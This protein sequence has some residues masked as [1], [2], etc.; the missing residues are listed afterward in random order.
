M[1]PFI[2]ILLCSSFA[3]V[4]KAQAPHATAPQPAAAD[5]TLRDICFVDPRTG[6]AVGDCGVILHTCDGGTRWQVIQQPPQRRFHRVVAL[7]DRTAVY[8]A[9]MTIRPFTARTE[10][11][12]LRIDPRMAEIRSIA[13]PLMPGLTGCGFNGRGL[14]LVGYASPAHPAGV[15]FL[16]SGRGRESFSVA[17]VD[18]MEGRGPKKTPDPID[19]P[20][21]ADIAE[22]ISPMPETCRGHWRGGAFVGRSAGVLLSA[23]GQPAVLASTSIVMREAPASESATGRRSPLSCVGVDRRGPIYWAAGDTGTVVQSRDRGLSWQ[24]AILGKAGGAGEMLDPAVLRESDWQAILIRGPH[25]WIA[26]TPGSQMLH[27]ADG[28]Q[29]WRWVET[30]HRPPLTSLYFVDEHHGWACGELGAILHTNDGGSTWRRQR[31]FD[32]ITNLVW[33]D[34]PEEIPWNWVASRALG[35]HE[36]T[37]V[38]CRE[39][40]PRQTAMVASAIGDDAIGAA[41]LAAGASVGKLVPATVRETADPASPWRRLEET[42][43]PV[44]VITR[45]NGEP[46]GR[47]LEVAPGT[48]LPERGVTLGGVAANADRFLHEFLPPTDTQR[49]DGPERVASVSASYGA[50]PPIRRPLPAQASGGGTMTMFRRLMILRRLIQRPASAD[51]PADPLQPEPLAWLPMFGDLI[52]TTPPAQADLIAAEV[53]ESLVRQGDWW[54]AGE[55]ARFVAQRNL[56]SPLVE[57]ALLTGFWRATSEEAG[58]LSDCT[59]ADGWPQRFAAAHRDLL[60][61]SPVLSQEPPVALAQASA[62]RRLGRGAEAESIYRR[63]VA[64]FPKTRFARAATAELWLADPRGQPPAPVTACEAVSPRPHLDGALDD[65]IWR[66]GAVIPLA[67]VTPRT[68]ASSVG[69]AATVL[70]ARDAEYLYVGVRCVKLADCEYPSAAERKRDADLTQSDRVEIL[71]DTDRD[72]VTR[73]RL[74]VDAA[75]RACETATLNP[76]YD[77][78]WFVAS[79]RDERQWTAEAAIPLTALARGDARPGDVWAVNFVRWAGGRVLATATGAASTSPLEFLLMKMAGSAEL[80]DV[81]VRPAAYEA[82]DTQDLERDW[83]EIATT[84][85]PRP[86]KG[87][88]VLPRPAL[89][90]PL[91]AEHRPSVRPDFRPLSPPDQERISNAPPRRE[92]PLPPPRSVPPPRHDTPPAPRRLVPP[93]DIFD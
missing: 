35:E 76:F 22:R 21:A 44:Q 85:I 77:P 49:G 46:R 32:R 2:L 59:S 48:L 23:D 45:T 64:S 93:K 60:K 29:S 28:G 12:L 78:R 9:G 19:S 25:I 66:S 71:I 91:P 61:G 34:T 50:L 79:T 27:S 57:H 36:L 33:A 52:E 70:V 65:A 17:P 16:D 67:P 53:F 38:A 89:P 55:V 80:P 4:A 69:P 15:F 14:T 92:Q 20:T 26:G 51:S 47:A 56:Q 5:A 83:R 31:G 3:T 58:L 42:Y 30:G 41:A 72:Y 63:I 37:V 8:V 54:A 6:W 13:T 81:A 75:G 74:A 18:D 39:G 84:P 7:P 86:G 73:I 43:R 10:A 68:G 11:V 82:P 62:L 88:P 40:R 24:A 1:R 90:V 87:P